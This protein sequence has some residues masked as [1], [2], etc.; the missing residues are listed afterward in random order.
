MNFL[1]KFMIIFKWIVWWFHNEF[2]KEVY[3]ETEDEFI[4]MEFIMN[5]W[6][7]NGEVSDVLMYVLW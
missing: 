1:M 2:K 3:Y 4:M 7:I 6:W 5:T